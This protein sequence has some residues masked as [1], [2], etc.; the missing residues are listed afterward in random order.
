MSIFN[1]LNINASGLALNRLQMDV[2]STNIANV[3]TNET[4]QG[5]PYKSKSVEFSE[6][7]MAMQNNLNQT[8]TPAFQS[9]GSFGVKV[10]GIKENQ[11]VKQIY[12]PTNPNANEEGYVNQS[13]VNL[14]DE[15][16]KMMQ[17]QRSYEA[18]I[19]AADMNKAILQKAL[20]ISQNG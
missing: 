20:T 4:P 16:V 8:S 2:S 9:V 11:A 12:D 3:N 13:N 6:N 14:A 1:S 7:L 15:M 19:S 10:N 5:G 18:N 17:A